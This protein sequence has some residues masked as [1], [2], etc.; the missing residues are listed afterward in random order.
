[1]KCIM[2]IA[3]VTEEDDLSDVILYSQIADT[4]MFLLPGL[5]GGLCKICLEDE[6]VGHKIIKVNLFIY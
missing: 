6:K 5:S 1:M 3:R 2:T 4:F